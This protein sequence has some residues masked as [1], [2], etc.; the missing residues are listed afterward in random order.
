MPTVAGVVRRLRRRASRV[1][2]DAAPFG[3]EPD[4]RVALLVGSPLFDHEWYALCADRPFGRR[5]AV[6][7]YLA[8]GRKAGLSPHPLFS[9]GLAAAR[10]QLDDEGAEDP[11]V[12]YVRERR[13]RKRVHPLFDVARYVAAQPDSLKHA[14]GPIAHYC[15]VGAARGA[16]V[17]DWYSP[18]PDTQPRGLVDWIWADAQRWVARRRVGL[19][20]WGGPRLREI[21]AQEAVPLQDPRI[22]TTTVILVAEP[23][24]DLGPAIESLRAQTT[25]AWELIVL[26]VRHRVDR[27]TAGIPHDARIQ[28]HPEPQQSVWAARNTGLDLARGTH[29]AWMSDA[30]V[31]L[32]GRLSAVQ[33]A[34]AAAGGTWAH[35]AM[36]E[37]RPERSPRPWARPGTR[38]RLLAGAAPALD[39]V[40]VSHELAVKIGG[41]DESL[42][43][44]HA[45]DFLLRLSELG[46]PGFAPALG[47]VLDSGKRVTVRDLPPNDRP[48]VDY[49]HQVSMPN[50]VLNHHLVDWATLE[51]ADVDEDLVSV[52]VPTYRDWE[53]TSLAVRRVVE[54]RS[55]GP[56][57][58]VVVV[59]NGSG[60]VASAVLQ[61]LPLRFEGVRVVAAPVN[62]GFALGNNVGFAHTRGGTV[63]FLNNDTEVEPGWLEPLVDSLRDDDVLAAQSLLIYPDGSIQSAGVVFPRGN[64]LPHE[65]LRGFPLED[66][67]GLEHERLH[68]LTG[69][70]L[71]M[72]RS[73]VVALRGFD[74]IFRNGME[75]IDIC[76]RL[77][78]TR[79]GHFVVRP[80]SRVVHHESKTPGR[81]SRSWAN[82]RIMLD[83]WAGRFPEDDIEVWGRRGFDIVGH[84]IESRMARDRRLCV[85]QPIVTR[86]VTVVEGTPS[87][88]WAIKHAA[89]YGPEGE[90]W[91]DTHFA[92][93][94]AVALRDLG[95]EVVIDARGAFDRPGDVVDD[96]DLLLRGLEP[97]PPVVDRVN[98]MWLISH[99]DL[100][101][102]SE[103]VGY[104]RIYVAS[105]PFARVM[106]EEWGAPAVPLLQATDPALF[107]PDV[108]EPDTGDRVLFIGN[109]RRH[110]RPL[111]VGAASQGL[112]L[113]IY[114][115]GWDG[116][117]EDRFVR[118]TYVPNEQVA[119]AYRSAGV[120]L[121][122]HWSDMHR[123]GFLSNRLFDAV[124]A[125]AR[126]VTDDAAGVEDVFGDSVR[127]VHSPDELSA[128][129]DVPDLDMVFGD[130]QERRAR[131]AAIAERHS[132]AA[133][134]KTLLEDALRIRS[135][136]GVG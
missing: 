127:V 126:V 57:V 97:H 31:W 48:M 105:V 4:P 135:A 119:A 122:D 73:D 102:R 134:A 106:A 130:D 15:E 104:D 3:G 107:H 79:P 71:A 24:R 38:A 89:P 63:V 113:S 52:V 108:A 53:M 83:R 96:V 110:A 33:R 2:A 60:V 85:A 69:A 59:D 124:A 16:R 109:S 76:L 93:R 46:D 47:V 37:L 80:D 36:R 49:A 98:L 25:T 8:T 29:V 86:Q 129:L 20:A 101:E 94:L 74:P 51:R 39:T 28:V 61:S 131:A 88:R 125:G 132:F 22:G 41:F 34:L 56:D 72:R 115:S 43:G 78:A 120:V 58:E 75:D 103:H 111:V 32:P 18:E 66:A 7:H 87:L 19:P 68:A 95:Q 90:K 112:P 136:R 116:I 70:A 82:R 55:E 6:E 91:G 26:G 27:A 35:D 11:L 10:L 121:N 5:E 40:V 67:R 50:V 133:R 17:N 65:F 9:P 100:V 1:R 30:A 118:G 62:H 44:G 12:V 42:S 45:L 14:G 13:Y 23:D 99:P 84:R 123:L 54:A 117:V 128:L 77:E 64:G 81:F 114:G 21:A 92:R